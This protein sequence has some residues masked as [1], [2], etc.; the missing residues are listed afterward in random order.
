MKSS[1]TFALLGEMT[2]AS[3]LISMVFKICHPKP[4]RSWHSLGMETMLRTYAALLWVVGSVFPKLGFC[5][6]G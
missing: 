1:S 6:K 2:G 5:V 3:Y 4:P